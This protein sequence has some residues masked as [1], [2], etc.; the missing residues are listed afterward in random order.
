MTK[1]PDLIELSK[2]HAAA[3]NKYTYFLLAASG[4]CIG[5][6]VQKT[7]GMVLSWNL[8]LCGLAVFCWGLSFYCGCKNV[9]SQKIA[10]STNIELLQLKRGIHPQQPTEF[11]HTQAEINATKE[12]LESV[13]S[14]GTWHYRWQFRFL[15]L[16]ALLFIAWHIQRM[17]FGWG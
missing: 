6:S 15:V 3:Q 2:L 1:Q 11:M 4:A 13:I 17:I 5:F 9:V 7:E 12:A 10:M 14:R 16:G 8:V